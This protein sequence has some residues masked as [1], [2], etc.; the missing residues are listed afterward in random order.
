MINR[1][2]A[3]ALYT[4][5]PVPLDQWMPP[6]GVL[7]GMLGPGLIV[8]V[9]EAGDLQVMLRAAWAL[10]APEKQ[11]A[12]FQRP[13]ITDLMEIIEYEGLDVTKTGGPV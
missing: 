9:V 2:R 12:F 7:K 8:R 10:L 1:V 6:Y 13:E 5:Q 3:C 11:Q 4:F